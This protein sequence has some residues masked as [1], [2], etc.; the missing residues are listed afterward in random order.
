MLYPLRNRQKLSLSFIVTEVERMAEGICICEYLLEK[1]D[2][3]YR[4]VD[5]DGG[6]AFDSIKDIKYCPCCG[7]ELPNDNDDN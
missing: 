4:P 7:K 5:W 3:L 6:I 2:I 1:G